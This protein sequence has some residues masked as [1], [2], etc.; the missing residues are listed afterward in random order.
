MVWN[1]SVLS[2]QVWMK[3]DQ[4][5]HCLIEWRSRRSSVF[6]TFVYGFNN[7]SRRRKL[8][9]DLLGLKHQILGPRMLMGDFN[10]LLNKM[11]RLNDFV[12]KNRD[13][14]EL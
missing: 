13:V 12:V 5:M 4:L 10:C 8:W 6:I 3:S 7:Q 1:P 9:A 14:I 2:V 11:D